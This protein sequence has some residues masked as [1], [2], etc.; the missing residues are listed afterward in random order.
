M[1]KYLITIENNEC[2]LRFLDL[3][4]NTMISYKLYV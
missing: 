4:Y 1:N 2:L 3:N